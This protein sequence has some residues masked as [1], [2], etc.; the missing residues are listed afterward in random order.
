MLEERECENIIFK[1]RAISSAQI[2]RREVGMPS[3]QPAEFEESYLI[4]LI[5]IESGRVI[6]VRNMSS[7]RLV[8]ER[9]KLTGSLITE[10]CLGFVITLLNWFANK[11]HISYLLSVNV[12]FSGLS[13]EPTSYLQMLY[14]LAYLKKC[15]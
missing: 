11:Q 8:C 13:S 10:V 1:T 15:I 2:I 7:S 6:Y 5:I 3:G 9:K 14:L 12:L 4:A